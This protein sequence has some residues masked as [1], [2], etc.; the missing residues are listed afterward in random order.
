M[1]GASS[2]PDQTQDEDKTEESVLGKIKPF[3]K[4]LLEI[5]CFRDA[6][7]AGIGGGICLGAVR[8]IMNKPLKAVKTSIYGGLA[9]MWI[10]FIYCR[11]DRAR[12]QRQV[13]AF[14][15]AMASST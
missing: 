15:K 10:S 12:I 11:Y 3:E 8:V 14:D 6:A 1:A 9:I 5:P 2:T 7:L 13:E 4:S